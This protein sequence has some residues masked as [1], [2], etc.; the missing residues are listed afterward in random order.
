MTKP[1]S[2]VEPD[3]VRREYAGEACL[4]ELIAAQAARTPDRVAVSF[5]GAGLTYAELMAR[6]RRLAARLRELGVGPESL[7]GICAERSLEMMVALLGVLEAGAAYVPIDP[8]YPAERLAYMIEDAAVPVLL[9]HQRLAAACRHQARVVFLDGYLEAG[10]PPEPPAS[11]R[12]LPARRPRLLIYTSGSTGRPKGTMNAHWRD[13]NRL[14]WMQDVFGLRESDVVLQKTP[15]SFD[16]SVWELFAPLMV[17]ARL[18]IAKPGGHQDASYLVDLIARER[19]TIA[20]FVPAM[21][22]VFLEAP[23]LERC[24]ALRQVLCSGEALPADARA[25][26]LRALRRGGPEL[27]NLYGP[28]EAAVEV[29]CWRCGPGRREAS[30]PIG[31][32]LPNVAHPPPRRPT[33]APVA[34]RRAGGAAHRRR[35]RWPAATC[36]GR[37]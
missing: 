14:L 2:P 29:T 21:L 12:G 30:V 10:A 26:L 5:E 35:G 11:S 15:F 31:R 22:R 24:D 6:A 16:V 20:H 23:G 37:S 32:P 3:I 25:P 1:E 7:V 19:V 4:H 9:T 27:H 8:A 13:R 28:T 33:C 36:A 34:A 18:V 17:G